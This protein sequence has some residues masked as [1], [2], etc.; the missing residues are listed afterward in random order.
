MQPTGNDD[1][2]VDKRQVRQAFD[3]AAASYDRAAVLQREVA[4]RMLERLDY[5]RLAPAAILDA[6]CG[7]GYGLERLRERY[8]QAT[9]IALDLAPAMLRY[10]R[11]R[12]PWWRRALG[13]QP[14]LVCGDLERLPL[15]P[16][17]VDLVWSNLTLQWCNDLKAAFDG[18]HRALTVG[19][20]F[21]FSTFGPDTLKELRA[22]FGRVDRYTHV[23]RFVDMH[24]IGDLLLA[25]GFADPVVD[26]E[27]VTVTYP[28][29]ARLLA[30]IRA[31]GA[32]NVTRGR[33]RGLMGKRAWQAAREHYETLRRDGVL[34]ATFEVVYGHAWKTA[35]RRVEDGRAIV[36]FERGASRG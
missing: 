17:S 21:M 34:P 25:A 4:D 35:P 10:V 2:R 27:F 23:N 24:D 18:V 36:R 20:L 32:H 8:P 30:E 26:M 29:F 19:G 12:A 1:A 31:I 33:R 14:G 11:E 13:R 5:V 9:R 28:D 7:T 6:G 15:R 22:A 3:R 16:G